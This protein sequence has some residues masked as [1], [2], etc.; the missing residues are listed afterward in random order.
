MKKVTK[1]E[2]RCKKCNHVLEWEKSEEFCD[3]CGKKLDWNKKNG[4]PFSIRFI[5]HQNGNLAGESP[6]FN[7]CSILCGFKW[8][9]RNAKKYLKNDDDF[10]TLGYWH[11]W[12]IDE[13][14][15]LLKKEELK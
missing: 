7:F 6:E 9:I 5:L 3:K 8:M 14:F 11:R 4:Y 15:R 10:F 1:P 12:N 13:L 2:I